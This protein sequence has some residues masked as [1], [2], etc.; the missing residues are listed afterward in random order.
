MLEK[1]RKILCGII[2]FSPPP[3]LKPELHGQGA[4]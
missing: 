3:P 2:F 1:I 4:E